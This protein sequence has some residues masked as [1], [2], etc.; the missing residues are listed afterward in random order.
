MPEGFIRVAA[1][2]PKIKV[3]DCAYN[4]EQI[5]TL[6]QKAAKEEVKLLCLPELCLTGYT[7][8]DLFLQEAL[9]D[10]AKENL[11]RLVRESK[12][13]DGL[14]VV[15]LPLQQGGKLY[16]T[17][18]VFSSGQILGFVPKSHL[19]NYNE[20]Y[21][22]R[23]FTPA[24]QEMKTIAF[25]GQEIPFGTKLIFRSDNLPAFQVAVEICEDLWTP[26]PP[27]LEHTQ[28]GATVICNLSASDETVGKAAY[29]RQ[30]VTGQSAR[31]L[32]GYLYAD[33]GHGESSTDMV[34]AGHNLIAENG[35]LLKE[36]VPFGDGWAVSE[37][38]LHALAHDR[39]RINTFTSD[40]EDYQIVPFSQKPSNTTLTRSVD[41]APFVPSNEQVM[42]E[43]CEE[44]LTMQAVGLGK[45]LEH[46]ASKAVVLGISG[47]LD[48]TLALLVVVRAFG[49]LS[50]PLTGVTAVTLPAFGTTERTKNNAFRLC[51]ALGVTCREIDI[52]E[53]VLTHFRDIGHP[54]SQH[55]VVYENAQARIRTL[56]LMDLANQNGG[57]VVG[58][59]DLSELALGWAT[60]NGDHMSM[61]A[62]NS[63]V[64]KTLVRHLVKHAARTYGDESLAAVLADILDTPVSPELLPPSEGDISQ[65]TEELVG[66]YELHDFFL[67]QVVR[68]GRRPRAVYDLATVAFTGVYA[69]EEILKWL[70]VFYRRFF[71]QQFKRSCLPDGPKIGSVTLSPRGDWR[72]PSDAVSALWLEELAHLDE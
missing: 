12:D 21:E 34:F 24:P 57:L 5:L 32:C 16:N 3:A 26:S 55:D 56:V 65:R 62:V 4:A 58:T 53:S 18:A 30:L 6:M 14:V 70:R 52:S 54:E 33:A 19:P 50:L 63:G 39:R 38:D 40:A 61:Y 9:L 46:T 45:R 28:A 69:A 20:F 11:M 43:R 41:S 59:G 13:F 2:T 67:Y 66:P 35:L 29:R 1:A 23:H 49:R 17:A 27:S 60:Y 37:L 64:P 10:K 44:I 36:S 72:M 48:S 22:L 31:L 71:A 7:C 47:G 8:G 68:W 42:A 15:G 51:E 25:E